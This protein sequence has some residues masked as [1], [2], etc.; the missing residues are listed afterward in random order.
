MIAGKSLDSA[1]YSQRLRLTCGAERPLRPRRIARCWHGSNVNRALN[2]LLMGSQT[3]LTDSISPHVIRRGP[4]L[5]D[6]RAAPSGAAGCW[7]DTRWDSRPAPA[8]SS[9]QQQAA[10]DSEQCAEEPSD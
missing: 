5:N 10:G 6:A 3:R 4:D 8:P 1:A 9:P 7:S 2:N